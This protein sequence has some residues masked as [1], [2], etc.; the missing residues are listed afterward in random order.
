MRQR[1]AWWISL[2]SH[3]GSEIPAGTRPRQ[4][5]ELLRVRVDDNLPTFG[6]QAI[7]IRPPPVDLMRVSLYRRTQD[8]AGLGPMSA[9]G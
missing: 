1:R 2:P 3:G 9:K 8:L 6:L 5:V 7:V 4:L